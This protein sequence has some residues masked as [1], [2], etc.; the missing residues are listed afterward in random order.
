MKGDTK[1]GQ[2]R[3][4]FFGNKNN[5]KKVQ[6]IVAS[7][8]ILMI[9]LTNWYTFLGARVANPICSKFLIRAKKIPRGK[10]KVSKTVF[11]LKN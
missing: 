7:L 6:F 8:L 4:E 1:F 2:W 3:T 9:L 11:S 5:N 10:K